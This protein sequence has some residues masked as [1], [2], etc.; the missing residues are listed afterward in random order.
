MWRRL[1]VASGLE[2]EGDAMDPETLAIAAD[3]LEDAF[4]AA[5]MALRALPQAPSTS[6][7][8][9]LYAYEQQARR[10]DAPPHDAPD[11]SVREQMELAT[12]RLLAGLPAD[13]ARRRYI[14]LIRRLDPDT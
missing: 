10:G 3:D 13:Q 8:I 5:A 12:W 4:E 1:A 11:A 9:R 7:A 6:V 2:P 14:A